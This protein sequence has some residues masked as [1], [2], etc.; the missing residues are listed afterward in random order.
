MTDWREIG[1]LDFHVHLIPQEVLE[2]NP[3]AAD[4]FSRAREGD[5]L[6]IMGRYNIGT[7]VV[8]PFNDPFL[9]SMEF[10]ADAVR[11]NLEAICAAHPGKFFAFADIDTREKPEVSAGAV[12]KA[13]ASPFFRGIKIHA[14][15]TGVAVDD[16][17]YEPVYDLAESCGVPVAFHSYP[18][19]EGDVCAPERIGRV[20]ERRP[21][22]RAVVCHLGGFQ[23]RDA[24]NLNAWFD[25][26]AVLPDLA[27][28]FGAE[29][30]GKI[31]RQFPV[32]RLLFASDWPCSRSLA[33]G[34]IFERT[35]AL[36]NRMEFSDAEAE[37]IARRNA[38]ELLGI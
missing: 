30:C 22:L 19:G 36:L 5:L 13:L 35:L 25:I 3:D 34:E 20:L 29:G 33:P 27:A 21:G 16:P 11:R 31:L 12:E 17:Y 4:E 15:N 38:E 28:K 18:N 8:M 2:A 9:M 37:K 26:S 14:A 23:W 6:E 24:V 10:T 32:E 1:K 7:S